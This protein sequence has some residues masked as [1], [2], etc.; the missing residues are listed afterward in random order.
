MGGTES[1]PLTGRPRHSGKKQVPDLMRFGTFLLW[2]AQSET[3]I[4]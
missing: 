3:G 2:I 1:C 4:Q